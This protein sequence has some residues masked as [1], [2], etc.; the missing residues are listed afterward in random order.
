MSLSPGM[1]AVVIADAE[2]R[3]KIALLSRPS[4]YGPQVDVV[5]K[6]ETHMSIVFFAGG[7]VYK[8]K[9]PVIYPFLDFSTLAAR[10]RTCRDELR[11]NRRLAPNVYLGLS[12][13]TREE[14]GRLSLDGKGQVVDWLVR[15]RRLPRERMLD[16]CIAS[17]SVT[18]AQIEAVAKLLANFYSTLA[19]SSLDADEYVAQLRREHRVNRQVL[20][21]FEPDLGASLLGDVQLFLDADDGLLRSRVEAGRIVD[22]HG[23]LRPEHVCLNTPPVVIDCLEFNARLRQVDPFDEITFLG[24]D[25]ARLGAA[26]IGPL[27]LERLSEALG[28]AVDPRL[29]HFYARYRACIRARLA[30][31]HLYDPAPRDPQRWAPVARSYLQLGIDV[32]RAP[33]AR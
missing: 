33:S 9:K 30:L 7:T 11:L 16:R 27:L 23:D 10:E 1:D 18:P 6:V 8:L 24:L 22:G 5:E 3:D 25:C 28:D 4:A 14:D 2:T 19:P 21:G 31:A 13:I 29:L 26:W 17:G 32:S 12:K 15:M 20:S